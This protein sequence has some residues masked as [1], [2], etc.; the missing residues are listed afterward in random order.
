MIIEF[1]KI[2]TNQEVI[3]MRNSISDYGYTLYT[4]KNYV[5][6]KI[7]ISYNLDLYCELDSERFSKLKAFY[8]ES[9]S[10]Y[11]SFFTFDGYEISIPNDIEKVKMLAL[12]L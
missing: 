11:K 4:Y 2:Y 1:G 12:L 7:D 3:D 6:Y 9:P 10:C 8:K 5:I